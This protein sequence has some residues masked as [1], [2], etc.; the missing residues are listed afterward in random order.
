MPR[1]ATRRDK[2]SQKASMSSRSWARNRGIYGSGGLVPRKSRL[3]IQ[4]AGV[5][6]A[7]TKMSATSIAPPPEV[8]FKDFNVLAA[9][10]TANW[11]IINSSSIFGINQG[12]GPSERIGRKIK[13]VGIV[14]RISVNT[15]IAASLFSP[16]TMDVLWDNQCNGALPAITDIYVGAGGINLPNP[17]VDERFQFIQRIK[18]NNPNTAVTIVD[19]SIKCNKT[20]DYKDTINAVTDLT[21]SNLIITFTSPSD[22]TPALSGIVRILYTDA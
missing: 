5:G 16:Y 3:R 20:I 18:Q 7:S 4:Q 13:V 17:L 11:T 10:A 2:Y 14:L 1:Y 8:K 15:D 21:G 22:A 12:T 6:G 9:P 19:R